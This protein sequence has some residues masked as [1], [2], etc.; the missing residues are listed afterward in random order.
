MEWWRMKAKSRIYGYLRLNQKEYTKN[1]WT[2]KFN[3]YIEENEI[4]LYELVE[5]F[6]SGNI[7]VENRVK[8]TELMAALRACDILIICQRLDLGRSYSEILDTLNSLKDKKVKICI[9][10]LP[11]FNNWNYI[12]DDRLYNAVYQLFLDNLKELE[13]LDYQYKTNSTKRGMKKVA[14]EGVKKIGHPVTKVPDYFKSNYKKY[15]SGVYGGM[16]LP[17][18]CRMNGISKTCY[19]KW[20]EKMK[21]AGEIE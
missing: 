8:F 3:V 16:S 5:E 1:K 15:K 2:K 21:K 20:I 19:Y 13:T 17:D 6:I 7:A 9:L 18:F 12:E 4:E 14:E 10:E 11:F